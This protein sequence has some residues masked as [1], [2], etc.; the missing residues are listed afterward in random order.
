MT[1]I[2][3]IFSSL[4]DQELR[5]AINEIKESDKTGLIGPIVR[6]LALKVSQITNT[7][8]SSELFGAQIL[9]L[10]EGAYRWTY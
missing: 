1:E 5:D 3:E 9:V 8:V 6:E 7:S 2:K 4:S 10:K